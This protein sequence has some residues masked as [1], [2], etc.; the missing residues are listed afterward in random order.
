MLRNRAIE[1]AY[2]A[3]GGATSNWVP[4][5]A[6]RKTNDPSAPLVVRFSS[7]PALF[8]RITVTPA[9][10]LVL[11][12]AITRPQTTGSTEPAALPQG[13]RTPPPPPPPFPPPPPPHPSSARTPA[14]PA[15]NA[16]AFFPMPG[17][18]HAL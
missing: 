15:V 10:G 5:V 16:R 2:E 13:P 11:R 9:A 17:A 18:D 4:A 12:S 6:G 14:S 3:D 7:T 1:V 8:R